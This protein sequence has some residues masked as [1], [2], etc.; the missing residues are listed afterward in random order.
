MSNEDKLRDYLKRAIADLH[1]T[2]EQLREVTEQYREPIAVV[3]MACRLPGGVAS[4]EELWDLVRDGVD[5]VSAFPADRGWDLPEGAVT[6]RE[7]GFLHDAGEFDAGFFGIAP[8]EALA[9]DPQQR[10]LLETAWEAVERAGIDPGTLTGT[11]TGVFVGTGHGGYD[12]ASTVGGQVAETAAGH[13]LTGN[14]VSVA[15]GRISYVLGLEGPAITVDTACSSSLVA[16][17]LA[18]QSLRRGE[19]SLALAGGVTVMSSPQM[20]TEFSRQGGLAADG[21]C[22]PFAAAADGTAWSEGAAV[23]LVER[24]SDAQRN[25]HPVLAVVRGS[26]VNQDGASNGLTAPNGPSQQRVIRAALA[27]AGLSAAEVDAV[28]A[29]GTGTRLGDPIEAHALLATYG[30]DREQP[31]L[32]GALKSNTGHTQAASG[33]AGVIKTVL[34]MRHGLLPRTLHLDAP[35][36]HVDWTAGAAELLGEAREWPANPWPRRAA[37]SSFGVSG[38]NAHVVL[39]AAPE[40]VDDVVPGAPC[41][42]AL[43]WVLSAHNETALRAQAGRLATHLRT[44][45]PL[46]PADVAYSLATGRTAMAHRA[47]VVSA[48]PEERLCALD[49]L[50]TGSAVTGLVVGV[51]EKGATAF[52]FSGQGSQRLGMGRELYGRFPVFARAFDA[53]CDELQLPLRDVVW[54]SDAELLNQTAYAQAG[55]FAVEVALYRLVE[56]LGVRPEFVAG[57]SIGEVAAA[58]VAGVFSLADA[59]ALVAARGRLMQALPPGGAMLAVQATEDEVLP[60][61]G[62]PVSI[63]AVNGPTSVVVSGTEEAVDAVR[64]HFADRRTTRLRV[65]HAFHSPLMDPMLEDFRAVLDGLSYRAPSIPLV[66]NLTGALGGDVTT[67]EYWVRHVREAV[68]F[69]DGV[70]TL[71]GA[72]ATRFLEL[73]P[74][75]VLAAMAAESLPADVA[76]AAVLRTDR[77]EEP[78]L[79]EALARLHV[80]GASPDWA[81]VLARSGGRRVDLPTYAFQRQRYW[82]PELRGRDAGVPA[83]D[84]VEDAFW[85]AVEAGDLREASAV[86]GIAEEDAEASLDRLLPVLASWRGQRRLLG[87]LDRWTYG[88]SWVPVRGLTDAVPPGRWLAVLP[89]G[90]E[91][92]WPDTVLDALAERGLRFER[93]AGAETLAALLADGCGEP[94]AGVLSF[95]AA[96]GRPHPDHRLVPRHLPGTVELLRTLEAAGGP[97][98]LWCLT[99]GAV[100]AEAADRVGE[101]EQAQLWGLGRV[102]ALEHP[103]RWGGLIDLPAAPDARTAGRLAALLA[104]TAEDQLALRGSGAYARRLTRR[105]LSPGRGAVLPQPGAEEQVKVTDPQSAP[106]APDG[107]TAPRGTLLVTGGLGALGTHVARWLARAGAEHLLLVGRRGPGAPGAQQLSEELEGLGARVTVA[108]CDVADRD[109]FGA[110]LA[111][112]PA[113]HPLGGVVHAA[114]VLD[115]G[116]LESLTADRFA[117]VLRAK[118]VSARNLHELT[119]G[120]DLALFVLFSSITGVLGNPGQANYAAANAYLDAL[121]EHRRAAG[122]RA[123]AVAWGPWAGGGMAGDHPGLT[124]RMR[125]SGLAPMDPEQAV[126]ALHRAL[127]ADA[128]GLTVADVDWSALAPVLTAARPSALIADLPEARHAVRP[129]VATTATDSPLTEQLRGRRADEQERLL[130][131][132]VRT[133]AAAVLGHASTAAVDAARAFR[134]LG[135]DSLTAVELRNRLTAATGLRLPATLLFDRPTPAAV[136]AHL[137]AELAG[138]AAVLESVAAVAADEP[139]AIVA[140]A[141]RFPGGVESPDD[142]WRLLAAGR[143][144]VGPFPADRGWDTDRLHH[145]DPDH[146]GTSYVS[147][148]AFLT[149]PAD[150]DAAFFGISPREALAMDP[151]QRLLLETVWEAVERSGI[152]P[153]TLHGSRTGV[154]VGSNFQD[155][156]LLLDPAREGVAGHVMTGNAASVI[157]GRVAYTLGLEGPAVTVDTACSSSL[158]ALHLAAQALRRGECSLALAGGVTVM[159]TP[160]VFVEFSRQRGLAPDG[161]CK[162]FADAADGT[163]WAEGVG[164]LLVERLSDA[165]RNGHPVL[166]VVRGSAVNQD[167]ASNGLTAPNGPSQ[168]RVIRAALADAGLSPAEVDAVEAH[169]TGTR[170][171]DPIEAQA[172][173]ATYGQDRELPLLLGSVKSNLGH[174]QA[175]AGIAGVMKTVLAMQHREL[176][177]SLHIDGP[178]AQV[179]WTAGAVELLSE[180]RAWPETGRPPRAGVS[181]FGVSGTNAHVILEAAPTP[182]P[183][184]ERPAADRP[185]PWLLSARTPDAVREQARRLAAHVR[186][187]EPT[188]DDVARSLVTTRAA[189]EHRAAVVAPD[190]AGL[191]D[192]LDALAEGRATP[193]VLE[194]QAAGEG[195]PV[196]VFPGQ[197]SQWA[198][199]AVELLDGAPAF[200]QRFAECAAALAPFTDWSATDVLRGE[201]GAPGLDRVDVVQPVLFAVMVSLA[202]LWRAHGVEP[203][204]VLGHS[205]GEIAAACVAGALT[206]DDAARV[207]ALRSRAIRQLAG[208]GG[209]VS[210]AEPA[211]AVRERLSRWDG[212]VS[213]AAV[214]GP[215][216]VVVSGDPE[217]LEE[218]AADC[219]RSGVRARR[220]PV[221]Y[222]SHSAH[223][224]RIEHELLDLLAPIA[225]RTADVPFCSTVTGAV[226]DT[227]GLDAAY[228]YRNLRQ[229][230]EFEQATRTLLAAGHRVFVEISPHPVVTTGVQETIEDS[231]VPAAA[232]GTLRRDEGGP[233]RF[234]LA[235]ADARNHGARMDWDLLF[236]GTGA[237]ATELP[238]YPF[239]RQRYWPRPGGT[240]GDV[241]T[242]G[243]AA[244]EHPL[245]GASVE[246]AQGGGLVATARWS[247]HTHPWLADHCVAGTVVVPGAALVEAVVRAGDEL[248]C[249]RIEELTLYAPVLLPERGALQVQIEVGA[250]DGTGLRPVALHSRPA[251]ADAPEGWTLH[252]DGSVAPAGAE[253]APASPVWPPVGAEPIDVSGLYPG[254]RQDGYGYGP[255]FRGVRA[256]WRL[257]TAVHAEVELPAPASADA[258]RYGLHPALLDAALHP[259]GLGPLAGRPGLP[260]AWNGVTLHAAGATALRVTLTPAGPDAVSVAMADPAGRPVAAI[261]A[262][263]V[264]PLAEGALDPA[265]RV[266]REALFHLDWPALTLA[267]P[268]PAPARWTVLGEPPAHVAAL[269]E[270]GVTLGADAD[271]TLVELGGDEPLAALEHAL[272]VLQEWLADDRPDATLLVTTR[273]AVAADPAEDVHDLPAAAVH[274]LVGSAQSEH[275]GRV[276]LVDL[277]DDPASWRALPAAL[278]TGEPRLALRHGTAHVPRL[279]RAHTAGPLPVPDGP[280][281]LDIRTK[282]S[283]DDLELVPSP[284]AAAPLAEGEVR[285]EV[286]AAGLN[287]RD[288]LNALDMY[289]GGARFLGAEAAGVVS[290]VGP[291]VTGFAVGDRVMGMVTGGFGPLA[292][293]DHR[294]L[295]RVPRGW[296]F[297]QAA[298]VPVVFLTAYYALR[299][300]AGLRDGERLLVHA[301]AGGVGMAATQLGRLWGAEVYGTASEGKQHLLR[302][303]GLPDTAIASSRTLDFEERFR[304]ATGGDGVDVVLNSLAGDYV[305]SSLRLLGPGGRLIEMGRTDVRDPAEVAAAHGGAHYRA[306]VLQEAGP[307]RIGQMLADLVELFEQGALRPLPLTCWDVTRAREAFRHMAQARHTGKIVL[308]V[309]RP[310]DPDGT[311]LITGGT[312]TLGAELARHLVTSRGVRHLL[313]AGR[314]GAAAPGAVEL[315]ADLTALGADARLAACDT[316]DRDA[317]AALL[318][319][320]PAEHPL[321]AVVHAAGVLDDGVVAGLTADRLAAVLRPKADAA[322]HL[323]ELTRDLDLADLVL[324]SSAAGVF[325]SPGQGSYAAANA[326]LDALAQHRRVAGLPTTALAWGLWAQASTMTAHLGATDRARSEQSGAL[327]LSTPDGLVLFDAAL[328][329]HRALL[330]PVRLDTA[331]L[332]SRGAAELPA[333]L[334]ALV[335]APARRAAQGA[336]A[337]DGLRA[338][339]AG[340]AAADR[341]AALLDLVSGCT[342]AVLGHS[343]A[344]Q[345]H[346]TRPFR[347]L[348]LDSLTAVELRNRLNAATGLRLPATLA[349]DHPTP[350]ALA[351]HLADGLTGTGAATAAGATPQAAD[352]PIAIVAMACRFPG[353]VA[354]PD[355]L[356]TLLST[357]TDA[358]AP[359]PAD[360][361]WDLDHLYDGIPDH[362]DSSR[363]REGGFLTDAAGFD[364]AFFGVSPNEAVAMDPQ[365]RLL[366][367][368]T[369]EA[370]ERAGI[371]PGT[372]RGSRTGVFAGLSSSDYLDRVTRVPDEA[373][374][375]VSTGNAASVISGRVAYTLG[376]EGPAVTVDTAC[377]SSLVALH[378]AV[379]ALRGGECTLALAGGVTV[380][381]TPMIPVDFARQRGLALDGR[382]KPFADAADGTGFSEGVGVLLVERLSDARR[383]GH[384]VLAVV[385]G[386]AVNQDGASNGLSAPNG[387][388]QQR[389][390]RAALADA[391]LSPAEVDAVEAHGTGTRLGDPIEAQALLATYG[392]DREHPLLV[393]S[394]KS[395][396]GHTQAAAGVAGVMRTVLALRHAALPQSLHIDRPT[397]HV[398][399]TDGAVD[400]LTEA[401]DWPA[402]GR[403][404]RAGVSSFGLSGT[405]AHVILEQAPEPEPSVA[406]P[407]RPALPWLLSARSAEALRCQARALLDHLDDPDPAAPL[408]LAHSL[409]TGRAL[410]EHRAVVVGAGTDDLRAGLAALADGTPAPGVLT[411]RHGAGRDRRVVL[412]FPGQG[413][414]WV[415]MGAELLDASPEF[416]ERIAACGRALAP[417]TD[418]SLEAVLRG[419]AD[420]PSLDRVDVAQPALWAT[421]IGLAACWQAHGVTPAAVL[422]HSQGEIAAA[423][424][425]GA[426]SLE[427][428]AKVVALRSRAIARGLSGHG[429]MVAVPQT[430]ADVLARIEP[431]GGRISVAAANGPAGVVVSGENTALDDLIAECARD[432]VRAKRIPVD[433]ASHSAQVE[434]IEETLHTELAGLTTRDARVP[435]FSTVTADWLGDTPLDAGY[436]YRNLRQTVRLEESVRALLAEGH[437]AFLECSPHPV[438]S[439]AVEDTAADA[440]ARAV[441]LGTVRRE[442]GGPARL[443]ASLGEA[444]VRGV[445]IDWRPAV[446]GGR[447]VDLPTYPF[448]RRRYWL[449]Q[450]AVRGGAPLDPCG[451]DAV[452]RLADGSGS[453]LLTGRIGTATHPWTAEHRVRGTAVV[454]GTALLDWAVRAGDEAGCP[455]VAELTELTPLALPDHGTVDLQLA[456]AP[457]DADGRRALT[458]HARPSDAADDVPWTHHASGTLTGGVVDG[459]ALTEWPPA[460]AQPVD[461]ATPEGTAYGERFRTVLARW[462]RGDELF[463]EVALPEEH[464][465]DTAGFRV[466]PGLLQALLATLPDGTDPAQP[467]DWRGVTVHA[468]GA[469]LLRVRLTPAA[470]GTHALTAADADGAPVL[471]ADAVTVRP[472]AAEHLAPAADPLYAVEW[473]PVSA[474]SRADAVV[475]GDDGALAAALDARSHADL[476]ELTAALDAGEPVPA[477]VV[478][479]LTAADE[480]DPVTAA[481]RAVRTAHRLARSW[482]AEP[483]LADA[484]LVLLT[485][486]AET[487]GP[488]TDA[489]VL[490]QAAAHGLVRSAQSENPGRFLLVDLDDD[491]ASTAA[492][493]TALAVPDE[494]RLAVR[495]GEVTAPRLHPVSTDGGDRAWSWDPA[496]T[497]LITGGTGTL[498]ALVARHL[499][500]DHGVR[501]L[502]LTGRRGPAA[503]GAAELVAD[504]AAL[505]ADA[506]VAACDAADRAALDALL[507]TVPDEHP[508]TGV[509]HAA[510]V[511]R[512]GLIEGLT[513]D[514][515]SEVLRPKVDAA[516]NLHGATR[517][518]DLSAFVLFSSF[519]ATAGG[520]GQA[521]YAAAN[522]FL[523]ALAHHRRAEGRPAVSLAWGYW[524]ESSGMTSTLDAVD[525]A[526]FARSGM[527]PLTA[528][529]GLALLD[530]ASGVDRPHLVPIRLDRHALA[531][532]GAPPLLAGLA[533]RRALRRT[534]TGAAGSPATGD[535]GVLDR[536]PGLAADQQEKLL[537]DVVVGH[538]AAVLGH[539]S[540]EAVDPERGFLDLGMSS[541]TAVEL[542]NRLNAELGLRLPTTTIFDHPSPTALAGRLRELADAP[543]GSAAPAARPVFAE[544]D[545]LESALGATELDADSRTR[546]LARLKSLQ[547]RLDGDATE[548]PAGADGPD[549]ALDDTTDDEMFDLIDR[550]LG[551]A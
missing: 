187:A 206:L 251:D 155:Y 123:T 227:A 75:G 50:A 169:G 173:L 527:L 101:P 431:Y 7:S 437:D 16:L 391:G 32:I 292:V 355:D 548:S 111:A 483:R 272:A 283:V 440:G 268:G 366:L 128:S 181:S 373:A 441:V 18:V 363:T 61:L 77:P 371:D 223:V 240:G 125:R 513:D 172:L 296:T 179:D 387:P 455:V 45:G 259:A 10:I 342:A 262:L 523:D 463:A 425:A 367:E 204:A 215:R 390:I 165:R 503:P 429:G 476:A 59:C 438:L 131:E 458:I 69:A 423:C 309:P 246:L 528:V 383:N 68:R 142:L 291:G 536:L 537:L 396:L 224:E 315:V 265:A 305:D 461:A 486:G 225:P 261:E 24:L 210:V 298:S 364:A 119:A 164:V 319:A 465:T 126:A 299:D 287:F 542:R 350:G 524:G 60:L 253:P 157:S 369:W 118:A 108:A 337:A 250:P 160:Q 459:E 474:A 264:R 466:H 56:S 156:H 430:H 271:V 151:Q 489:T 28:E 499:V 93:A 48:D 252:A 424:V 415:G 182:E 275:P 218:L 87:T 90:G 414:Q 432:G 518:L 320:V 41:G 211:A 100:A 178:T 282:G 313:L 132:L 80:R 99:R 145:P 472:V 374:P 63:A 258:A 408:D 89:A 435:F 426:L 516:W 229:T 117:D 289:P 481:H 78:A 329:D 92:S 200:A 39:E 36:P 341:A 110:L 3:G 453:V 115:D 70:R 506:C 323:H 322:H 308:T 420:A 256:A 65:S 248:G 197:G 545:E 130:L 326:W 482:L 530:A 55:L 201:P 12:S 312:G 231:G 449:A 278:A 470:D 353:G 392:Q 254:L 184:P 141:C 311:V 40:P 448:Q 436:W 2:R 533:P 88:T 249:G 120:H 417:W 269:A 276:V 492:L 303:E 19:C 143:D 456:A 354:T 186:A 5:A 202:E 238:T 168:Q 446:T 161:R 280:W 359:F 344:D 475:L 221:D 416:A 31:V 64:A 546:L 418:W 4:P 307:E 444:H 290:E 451:L 247:L 511:L 389:V 399:W 146:E 356:W 302:A 58:H 539:S 450:D 194:G 129:S 361:G 136:A 294:V 35:T 332:R 190:R 114:G 304:A 8:R 490:A 42:T 263:A 345:V 331:G 388:S 393:G 34:A 105:H 477:T 547:W 217:A 411:G 279:A 397:T 517:D 327:T 245:L 349:F 297:A 409:A 121:A 421:M 79:L 368:T 189:L 71:H 153:G 295:A 171:G 330:V 209:M 479:R 47:V 66:S 321:T 158:V 362:P 447:P 106:D 500:T 241:T 324:F 244:P 203:A 33:V 508:L 535:R 230:V 53:V 317:L 81:A 328:A 471:T 382:C 54:G 239:Q 26:A 255:V 135:F 84:P 405:N 134:D 62:D 30:Q 515:L 335:R 102:A 351:G 139:I 473:I 228:W 551:L 180:A 76:T 49:A 150:F 360:R 149:A 394:V 306:F 357:G 226:I 293:A 413:S 220:I 193:A 434:R 454:P 237:R 107:W 183:L 277:D 44:R 348:G 281:R 38:T 301:A 406:G 378:L 493:P 72:G 288:V 96:D 370:L 380:M 152:D 386:S 177:K 14:T 427:D 384:P 538:L 91:E 480:G 316:A 284:D 478:H 9:M 37:V 505:G 526:R 428:G 73:G 521:N 124:G 21:R 196:F 116:V 379:R 433:Y 532:V 522:A 219:E 460:G 488:S 13:L 445:R 195:A 23:L 442:D 512:D 51:A 140:M 242:A 127:L 422:G 74:D 439:M 236:A 176:P 507:A 334:R 166:A 541:L 185:L 57:H 452:V 162:P 148:G 509:V 235:L 109:A 531:T 112:V 358:I 468:T 198:G 376:L 285:I 174:T 520:P 22:K 199:M 170:L 94:P 318:A 207:V 410:L 346:A 467:A 67:P 103:Q 310:W 400:L 525:I 95:L 514:Q 147:E 17:H 29:H 163:G 372:L 270:A 137:R 274:G 85:T 502:L 213:V 175:A 232:L 159:S 192:G 233:G 122:L 144:A 15:S 27:D 352:E 113:E 496:G 133:E 25:G 98:R 52:L 333:L 495:R 267:G 550:E 385:R 104:Q 504:L 325:G 191:L 82:L 300:L 544:L 154:F 401:R 487:A 97:A 375:Y 412:V 484:R 543:T 266:A 205:Q 443:L 214:N 534:A 549:D 398:D 43:P 540:P 462:R 464:R 1:E 365:Q 501:H 336:P 273:R 338:R 222:A 347:D 494:P 314:A 212:R 138:T 407:E 404:R 497:V 403:P 498:G 469:T 485:H 188:L 381:S 260:F 83:A 491:P 377:S 419:A 86:L 20:F 6:S 46:D 402:T 343:S 510:G 339:L 529:Q 286:R 340:L 257:G 243:L 208:L 11:P 519:A 216:S 167:G 457:A 234:L 395:N